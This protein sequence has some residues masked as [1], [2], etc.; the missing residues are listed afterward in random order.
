MRYELDWGTFHIVHQVQ[1][2]DRCI[3]SIFSYER[4]N[5]Y[6]YILIFGKT[7]PTFVLLVYKKTRVENN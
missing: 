1:V 5:T 4:N 2:P 6:V 7:K 3:L